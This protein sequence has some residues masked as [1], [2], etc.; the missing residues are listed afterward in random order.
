M[1]RVAGGWHSEPADIWRVKINYSNGST[2]YLGPYANR[3]PATQALNKALSEYPGS[4]GH[5][6]RATAWERA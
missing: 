6:E 3:G 2:G 5:R 4:T 1:T